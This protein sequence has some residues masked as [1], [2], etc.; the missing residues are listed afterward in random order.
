M[1]LTTIAIIGLL[2]I[3][4]LMGALVLYL[5]GTIRDFD[6]VIR[7]KQKLIDDQTVLNL[8]M[9]GELQTLRN[10]VQLHDRYRELK[11]KYCNL[12]TECCQRYLKQA[13]HYRLDM[14]N[15]KI[16]AKGLLALNSQCERDLNYVRHAL[17]QAMKPFD[18]TV[19][20]DGYWMINGGRCSSLEQANQIAQGYGYEDFDDLYKHVQEVPEDFDN[21]TQFAYYT[22]D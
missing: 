6:S 10:E 7:D 20:K 17:K 3:V 9:S 15:M 1:E 19:P 13:Q 4:V 8:R 22:T 2:I 12:L 14:I 18:M 16:Y 5:R 21:G 11:E